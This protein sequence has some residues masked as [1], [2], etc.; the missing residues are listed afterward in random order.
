[1]KIYILVEW[2]D[3]D[4]RDNIAVHVDVNKAIASGDER[5]RVLNTT[6][7]GRDKDGKPHVWTRNQPAPDK[8]HPNRMFSWGSLTAWSG[9]YIE[10]HE[11]VGA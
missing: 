2:H 5:C 1:M 7:P 8:Y 11:V 9:L 3:A 4:T 10:E 6:C